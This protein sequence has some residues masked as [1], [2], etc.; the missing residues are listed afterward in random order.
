MELLEKSAFLIKKLEIKIKQ[1]ETKTEK[2]IEKI[3]LFFLLKNIP[4]SSIVL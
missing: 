1:K 3:I 4:I 2:I